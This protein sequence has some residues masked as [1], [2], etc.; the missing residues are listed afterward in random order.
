MGKEPLAERADTVLGLIGHT[1][2]VRLQPMPGPGW[3]KCVKKV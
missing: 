1:P 2:V 3:K